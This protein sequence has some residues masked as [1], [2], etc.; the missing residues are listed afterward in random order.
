MY[1]GPV[2]QPEGRELTSAAEEVL[3]ELLERSDCA[4]VRP[5]RAL[6]LTS[7]SDADVAVELPDGRRILVESKSRSDAPSIRR[8][9]ENLSRYRAD[10]PT[11]EFIPLIAVPFMG[12]VGRVLCADAQIGWFDL[13]GNAHV[14]APGLTI[15][16]EGRPN[17]YVPR[18]RP[19]SVFAPKSAR[20]ARWLLLHPGTPF[21]Q[22]DIARATRMSQ[23][24]VSRIL[25]RLRDAALVVRDADDRVV[26][27]EPERLLEAWAEAYTVRDHRIVAGIFPGRGGP[28]SVKALS[29]GLRDAGIRHAATGLAGAWFL[30]PHAKFRLA[31]MYVE[32]RP[33]R[34]VLAKLGFQEEERGANA[35]LVIP[36]DDGVFDGVTEQQ[37]VP[38][39]APVQVLL[40]LK[41]HPERAAEAAEALRPLVLASSRS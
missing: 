8:A 23:A 38:C 21:R 18:G 31:T 16:I 9:L 32:R 37:G 2:I 13:S 36:R 26:V 17:R 22:R 27:A 33:S 1:I 19:S 12:E 28:E 25:K 5:I 35:W 39:A 11:H 14:A 30:T 20:V 41:G 10:H 6:A 7:S 15:H 34:E 3:T 4:P 29:E 40:D 24:F